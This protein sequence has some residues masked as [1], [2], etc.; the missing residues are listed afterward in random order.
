MQLLEGSLLSC[1][2]NVACYLIRVETQDCRL[3]ELSAAEARGCF[4]V[5]STSAGSAAALGTAGSV[6]LSLDA[7]SPHSPDDF[8]RGRAHLIVPVD[9][10]TQEAA[11]W[12]GRALLGVHPSVCVCCYTHIP[13][14]LCRSIPATHC[15]T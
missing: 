5:A 6:Q 7:S 14:E 2:P 3:G 4:C 9:S 13:S 11:A 1:F 8:S 15:W 12:A 10:L